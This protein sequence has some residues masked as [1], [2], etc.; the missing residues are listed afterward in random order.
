MIKKTITLKPIK[1]KAKWQIKKVTPED[2]KKK[3]SVLTPY[4]LRYHIF[5]YIAGHLGAA[6]EIII[7]AKYKEAKDEKKKT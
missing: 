4:S 3:V 7:T 5:P 6:D 1:G 2:F